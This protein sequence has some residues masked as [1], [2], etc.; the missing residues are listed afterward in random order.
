[1]S[2][3][4]V[5]AAPAPLKSRYAA[6]IWTLLVL[7]PFIAEVL[8]G[9][10]RLS[11]LVVFIPEMLVWGGGALLARELVRR[12]R[13]GGP[14]LLL[15]GLALSVAEEFIIQQTSIAPLPFMGANA[16]YGRM[17]GVNWVYFLFMLGFE[18][19]WVVV[20]PVQVAELFFPAHRHKPWLRTRGFLVTCFFFLLGSFMAWYGW[21]QQARKRL[22]AAPYSPPL[23]HIVAGIATIALLI[24]FAWMLRSVGHAGR[25]ASGKTWS[26]WLA[27]LVVFVFSA[28]WWE[29]IT[30]IF[31]PHL[32]PPAWVALSGGVAW[33]VLAFALVQFLCAP[34]GFGRMHRWACSFAAILSV[35]VTSDL[36]AAGWTRPDLIAKFVFQAFGIAGCLW[37]AL[38]LQRSE[39]PELRSES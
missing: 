30:I 27:G 38:R 28:P 26:P 9:S 14:S 37:L 25:N 33:A 17:L 11:F 7:A 6:P 22:G 21:T 18:S 39:A 32:E 10:T 34:Q 19:I 5:A 36:S 15:L 31:V 3:N 24:L 13:A 20:V 4:P 29:L 16:A 8:S 2:T 23:S 12:W 1:M 35:V